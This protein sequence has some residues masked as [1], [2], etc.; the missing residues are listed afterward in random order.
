MRTTA[1][2]RPSTGSSAPWERLASGT[3]VKIASWRGN[4]YEII[5]LGCTGT[6]VVFRSAQ[7]KLVQSQRDRLN[8]GSLEEFERGPVFA[9]GDEVELRAGD[10]SVTGEVLAPAPEGWLIRTPRGTLELTEGQLIR[11][12][13]NLLFAAKTLVLG[14]RF[15]VRSRSERL[16][17]GKVEW[18][19]TERV[20]AA[21]DGGGPSV[22]LVL[23]RLQP[24]SLR[25]RVPVQATGF[26][27]HYTA[28]T[29]CDA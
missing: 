10:A 22:T 16:Y 21:L 27:R 26:D 2:P 14:D 5:F 3:R 9:I 15:R 28:N 19:G 1:E 4:V 18:I 13:A 25:V 17:T 6:G 23:E 7:G 12:E 29:M 8:W 11:R 24:E 20:L